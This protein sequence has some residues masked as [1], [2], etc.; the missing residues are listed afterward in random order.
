[1]VDFLNWMLTKGETEASA[2]TYAPLPKAVAASV[3]K[4]IKTIQ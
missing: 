3:A 4:T 1:M 2:L